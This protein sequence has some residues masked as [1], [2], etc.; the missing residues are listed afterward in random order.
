AA[1]TEEHHTLY[2]APRLPFDCEAGYA[3]FQAGWATSK[4]EWCCSNV[5]RG[6]PPDPDGANYDCNAGFSNW[7]MGWSGKKKAF[8][9]FHAKRGCN[10][11]AIVEP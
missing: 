9:C 5:G 7:Q 1:P 6:C 4:K 10:T 11:E 2:T 8:C 3:N